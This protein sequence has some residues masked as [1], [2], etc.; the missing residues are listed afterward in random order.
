MCGIAGKFNYK[1][2]KPVERSLIGSMCH[3][4]IHRGPD[5]EGTYIGDS[6]GMGMRRL[7]IIDLAGGEQPV[8]NETETVWVVFN[9]EI[10]NFQEIRKELEG[11]GHHFR[12]HSDTEVIV[13]AYEEY[14]L[15]CVK[16][17]RGM[18]AF[19]LWD[20]ERKRL[21]IARDR[22]GKK[23]LYYHEKNGSFWFCSELQSMLEDPEIQ[24]SVN[25]F[26]VDYY[27]TF[28][29]IPSPYT[30]YEGIHKLL[31]GH[32]LV[33]EDGKVGVAPYWTLDNRPISCPEEEYTEKLRSLALEAVKLRLISDVPLGAFL[34][35]GIDSS[36]IV[37]LMTKASNSQVK[38]F[39]IGFEDEE[40]NELPYARMIA[41]KFETDHHEYV[42]RADV[43]DLVPK[44]VR[45]FGEPFG[46]SSAI[47]TYYVSKMA[48]SEVTVTLSGDA[49]D[50]LF[51]GYTKYAILE[52]KDHY[53]IPRKKINRILHCLLRVSDPSFL[54][55]ES[56]VRQAYLSLLEKVSS[57]E[58]RDYNWMIYLDAY[59]KSKLYNKA[60]R[61]V[62]LE[63]PCRRYYEKELGKSPHSGTIDRIMFT[64]IRNYLP[65]DLNA[66]VD[67]TSMANSLE[68]RSPFQDHKFV[69]FA[70]SI[71]SK[72]KIR[73]G[74]SKYLLKRAFTDIIPE[75]I[76]NR[77]KMGFA[78]PIDRWFRTELKPV[79]EEAVFG[80]TSRWMREHFNLGFISHLYE[81]H[82]S[83]RGNHGSKLWLILNFFLWHD[84]FMGN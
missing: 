55:P 16:Y 29:Y 42:V 37:G 12:T 11:K 57:V 62:L 71:P 72:Y 25:P 30:I 26:A 48:R 15:E 31:P 2:A 80:S 17:F 47:P 68:V 76:R 10:Y 24:R 60:L 83:G 6:M 58:E 22:L 61:G 34:S 74:N 35:G 21:F 38:T 50:E 49:G 18:F 3:Q 64:D 53:S 32:F 33:V 44:L 73:D 54:Q 36:I 82:Q 4:M 45:H 9:G 41:E 28:Q 1:H 77:K 13:H 7:R 67:I 14:G 43:A 79:F 70:A 63:D 51:A 8:A 69:E 66:K 84:A 27:F 81:A 52:R 40:F 78:V 19:A 39:S 56:I 46:D 23:P 5:S 65:D 75:Q 20:E 59:F